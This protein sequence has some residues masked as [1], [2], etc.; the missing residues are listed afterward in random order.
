MTFT[1]PQEEGTLVMV[2]LLE[3]LPSEVFSAP[4]PIQVTSP[5]ESGISVI[6]V[7]LKA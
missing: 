5:Q 7:L 4:F 3:L 2:P 6:L 1:F